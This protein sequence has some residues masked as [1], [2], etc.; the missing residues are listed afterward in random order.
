MNKIIS[1]FLCL[2]LFIIP[3]CQCSSCFCGGDESAGA[4]QD[5]NNI[6]P[7]GFHLSPA[8]KKSD[9]PA[10]TSFYKIEHGGKLFITRSDVFYVKNGAVSWQS[11]PAQK[12]QKLAG[13]YYVAT[14]DYVFC[15]LEDGTVVWKTSLTNSGSCDIKD[16]KLHVLTG[17]GERKLNLNS[18]ENVF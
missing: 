1:Y 9:G 3:G 4:G 8:Q 16:G 17:Q 18:G 10:L 11:S 13:R 14:G 6:I 2:F 15:A 12:Y 5:Q 7:G